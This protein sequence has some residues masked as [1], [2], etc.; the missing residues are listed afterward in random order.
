[1][2]AVA[3]TAEAERT[4]NAI[5]TRS[6]DLKRPDKPIAKL[7]EPKLAVYEQDY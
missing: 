2:P 6:E 5:E 3:L 7:T 1:M 4:M